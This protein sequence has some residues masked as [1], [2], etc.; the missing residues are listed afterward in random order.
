MKLR[1][2]L[3]G[4]VWFTCA[5]NIATKNVSAWSSLGVT[6][7]K[8]GETKNPFL[9]NDHYIYIMSDVYHLLKNLKNAFLQNYEIKIPEEVQALEQLPTN[10]VSGKNIAL[11]YFGSGINKVTIIAVAYFREIR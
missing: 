7:K 6:A 8:N 9:F 5:I 3:S 2:F 11:D 4:T 10:V 1:T